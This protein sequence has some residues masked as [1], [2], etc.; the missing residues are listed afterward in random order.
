MRLIQFACILLFLIAFVCAQAPPTSPASSSSAPP[1]VKQNPIDSAQ[2]AN[3]PGAAGANAMRAPNGMGGMPGLSMG[4][5]APSPAQAPALAQGQ[6]G[7]PEPTGSSGASG[8]SAAKGPVTP[9]APAAPGIGSM[10]ANNPAAPAGLQQGLGGG[11][12]ASSVLPSTTMSVPSLSN[13][14]NMTTTS[15]FS[16]P[17]T[18]TTTVYIDPVLMAKSVASCIPR[19]SRG[20]LLL[21]LHMTIIT[22]Q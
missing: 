1:P 2:A 9:G 12:G 3:M 14:T 16:A 8:P 18:A 11:A 13:N 7:Q 5:M 21:L 20:L 6:K 15:T 4:G 10:L 22:Y 17:P 19:W